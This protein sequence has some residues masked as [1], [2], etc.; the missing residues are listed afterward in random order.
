V[1]LQQALESGQSFPLSRFANYSYECHSRSRVIAFSVTGAIV[2]IVGGFVISIT[3]KYRP[4][5]WA[6]WAISVLGYGL[7]TTLS[8]TSNL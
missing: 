7:M 5:M 8:S 3:G 2:A 1:L 6:A 4:T